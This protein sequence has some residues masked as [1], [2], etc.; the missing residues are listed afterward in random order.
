MSADGAPH[1][2]IPADQLPR[3]RNVDALL[4]V[5]RIRRR[6]RPH[7]LL[8]IDP[9]RDLEQLELEFTLADLGVVEKRVEKLRTS[10]R[11][12]TPAEREA[13]DRELACSSTSSRP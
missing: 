11:H 1:G 9:R 8:D 4:H 13:N 6:H 7:P 3:L 2:D 10:G 5:A 12:G